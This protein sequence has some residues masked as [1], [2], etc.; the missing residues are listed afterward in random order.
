MQLYNCHGAAN[1]KFN[2]EDSGALSSQGQLCFAA[3]DRAPMGEKDI[4]LWSKPLGDGKVAA[5]VLNS[6]PN[7]TTK[8]NL[9]DLGF[10]GEVA[11]RDVWA[12]QDLPSATASVAVTLDMHDS[13]LFVLTGK[14]SSF[15]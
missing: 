3:L 12:R 4:E 14:Q 2:F 10:A 5:F 15:V 6:G 9:T 8:F 11:V 7:V 13:A 1:E